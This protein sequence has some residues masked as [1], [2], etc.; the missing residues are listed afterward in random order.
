MNAVIRTHLPVPLFVIPLVG[1][2][3]GLLFGMIFGPSRRDAAAPP[4]R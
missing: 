2:L 1:G 4:S 3:A